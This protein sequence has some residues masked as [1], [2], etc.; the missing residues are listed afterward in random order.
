MA[1]GEGP[2]AR[3]QKS[4]THNS[5][6]ANENLRHSIILFFRRF[7]R[8]LASVLP[9]FMRC[10]YR[11]ASIEETLH[12]RGARVRRPPP[13]ERGEV[14]LACCGNSS[15][16]R[17]SSAGGARR[18]TCVNHPA[19]GETVR[20]S[21]QFQGSHRSV[22]ADLCVVK[23]CEYGPPVPKGQ[24]DRNPIGGAAS[25]GSMNFVWAPSARR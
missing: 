18:L 25:F 19:G 7:C 2:P 4:Q 5:F 24:V 8:C 21:G 1:P 15:R 22:A 17:L 23:L 10:M 16:A 12:R 11:A 14:S 9:P 3:Q 13:D 20:F 6:I